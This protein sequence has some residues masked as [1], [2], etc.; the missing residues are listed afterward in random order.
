M[1]RRS[2]QTEN[3]QY[4]KAEECPENICMPAEILPNF[5]IAYFM[6]YLKSPINNIGHLCKLQIRESAF[7][8]SR[9]FYRYGG[10]KRKCNKIIYSK[11]AEERL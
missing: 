11:S 3:S 6:G 5:S 7:S 2:V 9:I 1:A 10:K 8:V 4:Y